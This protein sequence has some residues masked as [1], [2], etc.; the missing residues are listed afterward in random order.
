MKNFSTASDI[1]RYNQTYNKTQINKRLRPTLYEIYAR[2]KDH[3]FTAQQNLIFFC[4][5]QTLF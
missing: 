2:D 5:C 1:V 4:V 3:L